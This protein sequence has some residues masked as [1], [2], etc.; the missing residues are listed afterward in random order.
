VN[1]RAEIEPF[2]SRVAWDNFPDV[3]I[4]CPDEKSVL[5]DVDY[6]AAKSGDADAARRLVSRITTDEVVAKIR[7]A[8]NLEKWFPRLAAVH[9]EEEMGKNQ[10]ATAFARHLGDKLDLTSA[11]SIVQANI[12]NHTR[13]KGHIRLARQALFVGKVDSD[14]INRYTPYF[15]ID[16]FI[17]QGGTLANLRGYIESNGGVVVGAA[18]L[19][20]KQYSAKLMLSANALEVL[21]G[22]YGQE[23]ENE[24]KQHFG[25]GFECLTASEARFLTE[26]IADANAIRN[27]I[28]NA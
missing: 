27:Q 26:K 17:G 10:I 20:G 7:S 3:I 11:V 24:W 18:V 22:K 12:V 15:L 13:A 21:R 25:F 5:S 14:E 6:A 8:L 28:F 2:A 1:Q 9:A 4:A 19:T 16:D 23:F